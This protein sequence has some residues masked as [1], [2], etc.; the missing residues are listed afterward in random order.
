MLLLAIL[1]AMGFLLVTYLEISSF[2][3]MKR[4]KLPVKI[5]SENATETRTQ[6]DCRIHSCFD[7]FRCHVDNNWK[8]KAY[9][10][11]PVKYQ[12]TDGAD[13]FPETSNEFA[14]IMKA[15]KQSKF[16]TNKTE[17]ACIF[18]PNMDMLSERSLLR[19]FAGKALPSL[20]HWNNGQNH[21]L[22]NFFQEKT[23]SANP[24]TINT[25]KALV[26]SGSFNELNFRPKFD[27]NIPILNTMVD[28]ERCTVK[29]KDMN[30]KK[31]WLL[32]IPTGIVPKATENDLDLIT[33]NSKDLVLRLSYCTGSNARYAVKKRCSK[34]I[35]Y[36]YPDILKESDFCLILPGKS[37]WKTFLSDAM[38]SGCIP[39][40]L[41]GYLL[42]F[43]SVLDWKR[44]SISINKNQ[45][46]DLT[47]FL[48]S[49]TMEQK[50]VLRKQV[51]FIWQ[52]YFSS[53]E[54]ITIA[55]IEI[56]NDR[57]SPHNT[58]SYSEWNGLLTT[59]SKGQFVKESWPAFFIPSTPVN[60]HHFTAVILTYN[61]AQLL[62]QLM[63]QLSEC[64]SLSKIVVVWNNPLKTPPER[65]T[66]PKINKPWVVIHSK[67]NRLSN[68]FHPYEEIE[69]NAILS[70]DD[71]ISMLTVTEVEFA[72]QVWKEHPDRLVG[73]P[74]RYHMQ[75]PTT[76]NDAIQY[77]SEW[78]N[79]ISM[80]LTGVAF[81]HKIYSYMFTHNMPL[82]VTEYIDAK[83]NC[84]DI[85][86]NFLI[87]N[88]TRKAP[89][90]VTARKRFICSKCKS[91]ESLWSETSHFVKRTEC[92]KVFTK[93][94]GKMPLETV[95]FRADPVLFRENVPI[96]I[97]DYP[98]TGT[99]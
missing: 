75:A 14:A 49:Y 45:F 36:I 41:Q 79:D 1:C 63:K 43:S 18:V 72:F 25:G 88:L 16:W 99:V 48:K 62:F 8:I 67:E 82:T 30:S 44:A 15:I 23:S 51:L 13:V 47:K 73:F 17:E 37:L 98:D 83:M 57:V 26:A 11:P 12:T 3:R 89:I 64:P 66:W 53:L 93:L 28:L 31:K 27:V 56:I 19:G 80:V 78:S 58:K 34:D 35:S 81:H 91:N 68:R 46:K 96:E 95:E 92:L 54:R 7:L 24:L 87:A 65:S 5:I 55:A 74:G 22:F 40:V 50:I 76:S 71:D 86:M 38:M 52:K 85:A 97:Q 69:T 90:K 84:E 61:R 10:Y 77:Q 4:E 32:S 42:P 39:L 59:L 6:R 2:V 70:I 20:D 33:K 94:F 29:E 9:V 21:L 60:N